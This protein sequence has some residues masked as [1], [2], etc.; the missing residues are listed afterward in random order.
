MIKRTGN[1]TLNSKTFEQWS[2]GA[3][4]GLGSGGDVMTLQGT[5]NKCFLLSAILMAGAGWTWWERRRQ[6]PWLA[7][8]QQA[9]QRLQRHGLALPP[10]ATP[11]QLAQ[12][13]AAMGGDV[14]GTSALTAQ[15]W[16]EW[17][18]DLEAWRYDPAHAAPATSLPALRTR[19]RQLPALPPLSTPASPHVR[20][21]AS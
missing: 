8:L 3:A 13:L 19:W 16:Q 11:R 1:P 5:V 7:L 17:L 2:T 21:S 20:P 15:A 4:A 12:A 14:P 9:R 18:L 10:H 6:D